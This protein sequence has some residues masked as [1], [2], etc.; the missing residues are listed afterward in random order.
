MEKGKKW[1]NKRQRK[2]RYKKLYGH[3]PPKR[4]RT[5]DILVTEYD[6]ERIVAAM[7]DLS[8][9]IQYAVGTVVE[10]IGKGL[11]KAGQAIQENALEQGGQ[12][13]QSNFNRTSDKGSGNQ[14][15]SGRNTCSQVC[16]GC[17]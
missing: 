1:M 7:Q 3:N 11:V 17:K 13:E 9:R 16:I 5:D 2:K 4:Y 14:N 6:P 10:G 15:V 8:S 12:N